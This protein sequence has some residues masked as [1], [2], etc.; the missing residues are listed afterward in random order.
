MPPETG[1]SAVHGSLHE[2]AVA[3]RRKW[4]LADTRSTAWI[5]HSTTR[6]PESMPSEFLSLTDMFQTIEVS[7]PALENE[8]LRYVT[9]KSRAL[10]GRGDVTLWVPPSAEIDTV[11]IL[12]H[13]VYNSHWAWSCKGGVHRI[14]RVAAG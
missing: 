12:L 5:R 1:F 2:E 7:E 13:G 4:P 11:L 6:T 8:N 3:G 9:V 14:A 10:G